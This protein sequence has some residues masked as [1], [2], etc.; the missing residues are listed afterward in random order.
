ML[1][2]LS[3]YVF[4]LPVDYHFKMLQE[5]ETRVCLKRYAPLLSSQA[6]KCGEGTTQEFQPSFHRLATYPIF[7]LNFWKKVQSILYIDFHDMHLIF[8]KF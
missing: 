1:S 2:E 3:N 5:V 6:L 7:V 8:P 4:G